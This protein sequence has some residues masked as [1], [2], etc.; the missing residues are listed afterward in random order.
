MLSV[1]IRF[2]G[3]GD[4]AVPTKGRRTLY[5]LKTVS[6]HGLRTLIS[7][8]ADADN[9]PDALLSSKLQPYRNTILNHKTL[10]TS[11]KIKNQLFSSE[12]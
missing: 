12:F 8:K 4:L 11:V 5:R 9:R 3:V 10:L 1:E 7:I 2:C 6:S